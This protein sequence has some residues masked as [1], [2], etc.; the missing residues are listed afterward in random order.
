MC[1]YRVKHEAPRTPKNFV[2][3]NIHSI[4]IFSKEFLDVFLDLMASVENNFP[5]CFAWKKH[6]SRTCQK[7]SSEATTC[8]VNS[9]RKL[10]SP[11]WVRVSRP[12]Q[13][14]CT[15]GESYIPGLRGVGND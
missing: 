6:F 9:S 3:I 11:L 14:K 12:A 8:G 7:K 15:T 5:R 10:L 13:E 2:D 1:K 4:S